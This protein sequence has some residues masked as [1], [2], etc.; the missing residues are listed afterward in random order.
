M[1]TYS[2]AILLTINHCLWSLGHDKYDIFHS[3]FV[4]FFF[5]CFIYPVTGNSC[6]TNILHKMHG[7][8]QTIWK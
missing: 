3:L 4:C 2:I 5:F 7:R 1:L 8:I 6:A